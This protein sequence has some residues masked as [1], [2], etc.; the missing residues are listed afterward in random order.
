[1]SIDTNETFRAAI[2]DWFTVNPNFITLENVENTNPSAYK[3]YY[4][5]I[6]QWKIGNGVTDMSKAFSLY[7]NAYSDAVKESIKTFN[8]NLTAWNTSRVTNM[9]G[10]FGGATIF[11]NGAKSLNNLPSP[12]VWNTSSVTNMAYMFD[13]A[14]VFNQDISSWDTSKVLNM[15][16]MFRNTLM[17]NNGTSLGIK[18]LNNPPGSNVWNTGSVTNMAD[19]FANAKMFNQDVSSWDTSKVLNM[20]GM[21]LKTKFNNGKNPGQ[22]KALTY[23]PGSNVWNTSSVTN[24]ADMFSMATA[25]NQDVSSWDTS[26]V[27][28]MDSMFANSYSFN[29]GKKRGQF[30][31]LT[32]TP[33][34]NVWKTSSV[35]N[36]ANMFSDANEFNQDISSWDTSN[37]LDMQN[38]FYGANKFNNGQTVDKFKPL[39]YTPGSNVWKTSSVT[40]MASMFN[41]AAS[42]NQDISSWDTSKVLDMAS[43]FKE[44]EVYKG[45]GI[46]NW[47]LTK[48]PTIAE[49]FIASGVL[50]IPKTNNILILNSWQNNYGYSDA[51]LKEAG[52]EKTPTTE[53]KEIEAIVEPMTWSMKATINISFN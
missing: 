41:G 48:K 47:K 31:P 15:E 3:T 17:F 22:F 24:M 2:I 6:S 37:V 52:L 50:K 16:C 8:Q 42:F 36:M 46:A 51:E 44:A 38:M 10:M 26:N 39:T 45:V 30:K 43:M 40:T 53:L 11:N 27:L 33:G 34:S 49:M 20:N 14:A 25:F 23:T 32:Y 29:N 21:F 28:N 18:P 12:N 19:M 5:P 1:M 4:G 13:K 9:Y 7:N 35:T